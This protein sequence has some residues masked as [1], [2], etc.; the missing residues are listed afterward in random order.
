M[1]CLSRKIM[2]DKGTDM[3]LRRSARFGEH[4]AFLRAVKYRV[5]G[6][7]SPCP[8]SC[9]DCSPQEDTEIFKRVEPIC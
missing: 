7:Q 1:L 9:G 3:V 6:S 4:P 5:T 2:V 8:D